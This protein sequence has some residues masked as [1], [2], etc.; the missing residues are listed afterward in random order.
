MEKTVLKMNCL[1]GLSTAILVS[2]MRHYGPDCRSVSLFIF[3]T[4]LSCAVDL[5][6]VGV[7]MRS[8][9]LADD[10]AAGELVLLGAVLQSAL[11]QE[12]DIHP[13]HQD[14]RAEVSA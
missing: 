11:V 3:L 4:R 8:A 9:Y 5:L 10:G 12:V 13:L 2:Y 6:A 7:A 1:C 14:Q